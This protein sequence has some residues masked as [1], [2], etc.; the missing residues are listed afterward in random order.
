MGIRGLYLKGPGRHLA[1]VDIEHAQAEE[2]DKGCN[3]DDPDEI[4][5]E[6]RPDHIRHADLPASEYNGIGRGRHGQHKCA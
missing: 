2:I 1:K 5:K 3:G 4:E 6:A